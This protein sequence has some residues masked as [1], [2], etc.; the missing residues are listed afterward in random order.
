MKRI[1]SL[2][3]VTVL[4]LSF[5]CACGGDS[6]VGTWEAEEDGVTM[7]YT[8]EKGGKG[9][10]SAEGISLDME[11]SVSGDKLTIEFMGE[12]EEQPFKLDGDKLIVGEGDEQVTFTRK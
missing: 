6:I 9:S 4:C 12:K 3:L 2:A 1:I 10:V 5:L 11:W 8:F 7:S